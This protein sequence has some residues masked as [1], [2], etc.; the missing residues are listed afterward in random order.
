MWNVRETQNAGW[1]PGPQFKIRPPVR[2]L[3]ALE[4]PRLEN[5]LSAA[6]DSHRL[7]LVAAPAGYGKSTFLGDWVRNCDLPCAW[8]SLDRFDTEPERLFHGV[9]SAIQAAA[10][11]LPLPGNDS[12]LALDQGLAHGRTASYDL[13]LGALEHL[14]EPIVLVIDDVHLAG[15]GLADGIVGVLAASAPPPL[16]LVLSGRGHPSIQL[17]RFRYGEGLGELGAAELAFTREEVAQF[18]YSL[19]QDPAFDAGSLWKATAGWPV[20]V[21]ASLVSLAQSRNAPPTT[22]IATPAHIP[23]A[24]YVAEEILDQ[25]D[26]SLAEFILRATTCDWLGRRLAVEL[27]GRPNGSVLLEECLR[28]GLFIEEHDYRG[29]ESMYRWHSLFAEQCRRIQ[30]RRDPLLAERLHRVAARYYQDADVVEGVA[31]TL[32]GRAPRQ[33]VMS[34]GAHWLEF[35]LGNDAQ[36]LERLCRDLPTPWGE[37]PEILMI[38]SVCRSLAGDNAA[39]DELIRRA[40][41]RTFVL[42]ATRRRTFDGYRTLFDLLPAGGRADHPATPGDDGRTTADL[43]GGR[44]SAPRSTGLFLLAQAEFRLHRSGELATALLQA[45]GDIGNAEQLDALDI[46]AHADLAL[47]FAAAG[48]LAGADEHATQAL[49]RVEALGWGSQERLAPAWLGRGIARYWN[50]ELKAARTCLAKAQRLGSEFF[51]SGPLSAIYRV[52]VDCATGDLARLADSSAALEEF[53]GRG[54][55]AVSWNALYTVAVAKVAE[56]KGDLEGALGII[57]PLGAGGHGALADTLLAELLRRG[58]EATT[59]QRCAELLTDRR[60]NPYIDTCLSLTEALLAH[61]AGD[62]AAAH[63][64]LEHAVERAEPAS[65]L[66]PFAE[67]RDELAD[68]LVQHAVW[69]TAHESFIAALMARDTHGGPRLRAQS[70]WNLTEREREV[71]AYMRSIMTAAEI[72]DALFISVNTV[73]THERSIYRKLGAGSRRDALKTAARRGIV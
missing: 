5:A 14:T 27:Y 64:R 7:T 12:L 8:L 66:R 55:Y 10:N 46:C 38:R 1:V 72:A 4:R 18:A 39:A 16:R 52:L 9:V 63:E 37:D 57:Q 31:Q 53:H 28:N 20:A 49:G 35:V 47:A 71:L 56:A 15:P 32:K 60:R 40:L 42:D 24:D 17:E 2:G 36:T 34:L 22:P 13:L 44:R 48:G 41:S 50:D 23:L 26:P 68:L 73:K 45:T 33:A 6:A 70:Y 51:P 61:G 25:L 29:G 19:G 43:P 11:K 69:G 30:E 67:R 3:G 65:I 59:A 58:G 62:T 21:H 54:K